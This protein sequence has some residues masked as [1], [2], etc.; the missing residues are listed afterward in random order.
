MAWERSFENRVLKVRDRELK[1]QK[2][3]YTIEV[4]S[5]WSVRGNIDMLI[6]VS[7]PCGTPFGKQ[8]P[9]LRIMSIVNHTTQERIS[10][11]CHPSRILALLSSSW[12]S[13]DALYRIHV[14]Q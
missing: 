11:S 7:R 1:Y 14:Y 6:S 9:A 12:T 2:L 4:S 13:I 10:H 8:T 5:V 3:N